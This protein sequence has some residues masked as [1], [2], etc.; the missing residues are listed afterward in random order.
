M[1]IKTA[2][3]CSMMKFFVLDGLSA[4]Q[5]LYENVERIS[6]F[7]SNSTPKRVQTWSYK[8]RRWT[9]KNC[10]TRNDWASTWYWTAIE[11]SSLIKSWYCL[12]YRYSIF[13]MKNYMWK[14]WKV[15]DA[16]VNNSIKTDTKAN[17]SS[18]QPFNM[19]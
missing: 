18:F 1:V 6:S 19:N 2:E 10:N 17:F 3:F 8:R 14:S 11:D 16:F 9:T 4:T 15:S 13:H 5:I 12:N 7:I